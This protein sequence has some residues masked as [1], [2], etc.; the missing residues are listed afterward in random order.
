M[1]LLTKTTI[2][3]LLLSIAFFC[4]GGLISYQIIYMWINQDVNEYFD[5]KEAII[6]KKI[7]EGKE[8]KSKRFQVVPLESPKIIEDQITDTTVTNG[9][10]EVPFKKKVMV[11]V[12][13]NQMYQITIYKYFGEQDDEIDAV[14]GTV[15][16]LGVAFLIVF[17]AFNYFLSRKI[18]LPFNH[19]LQEIKNFKISEN[20]PLTLQKTNIKEFKE[21]N[22]L[23][24]EM[25]GKIQKDYN[26]LKEFT[27]N[28]SH[29]I[30]TPLAIIKVKLEMLLST[31][32]LTDEQAKLV[33]SAYTSTSKLSHLG[34]ALALITRI[35]NL[36]FANHVKEVN[37][38][39]IIE[40]QLDNFEEI[41]PLKDIKL[42]KD[43]EPEVT[44]QMAP[45]L[46]DILFSNLIKNA[47]KH[48]VNQGIISIHLN[49]YTFTICNT[50]RPP[51]GDVNHFFERFAK[52]NQASKSLGLGLAIVKKI[53]DVSSFDIDY[54]YE[55]DLHT[56]TVKF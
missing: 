49:S 16:Y 30:Q 11:R 2:F 26:N 38:N 12:I 53:C 15:Y 54:A 13:D 40:S 51:K 20:R 4:V 14:I 50:G 28:A 23:V 36:E 10:W 34:K 29:E 41:L 39:Q 7:L 25:T 9:S 45:L 5:Y 52:D 18:W 46:A 3:H 44:V 37:L 21:L 22:N 17:I 48:N 1:K 24:I 31:D 47:I 42:E 27:E 43:L 6:K 33:K 56:I 55:K 35:E 19:T 8:I 32:N